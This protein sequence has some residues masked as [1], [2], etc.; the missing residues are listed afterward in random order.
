LRRYKWTFRLGVD[1]A[2]T[3]HKVAS[4][5][6]FFHIRR[7][8]QIDGFLVQKQQPLSSPRSC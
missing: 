5:A 2:A 3:R 4:Y 6:C 1:N 7:L 8:K